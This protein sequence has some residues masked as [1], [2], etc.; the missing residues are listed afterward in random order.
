MVPVIRALQDAP[1]IELRCCVSTQ[2]REMLH[3][4]LDLFDIKPDYDLDVMRA[5]QDLTY[6]TVSVLEG[7]KPILADWQPDLV[8][9]HGDTT[10]AYAAALAAFYQRIPVGHVE[11]GL[12]TGDLDSPWPEEMNRLSVDMLSKLHFAP[13]QAAADNLKQEGIAENGIFVTGNTVVDSLLLT[14][15]RLKS[16]PQLLEEMAGRF[17]FLS[18]NLKTILVTAHRRESFGPGFDGICIALKELSGRSDIQIVYPVHPNPNVREVVL[19]KLRGLENIHLIEPL[20][21]LPFV[22]LMTRSDIILTDSGGIQEEAPSLDKPVLVMRDVTERQEAVTAGTVRMVGTDAIRIVEQASALL[23][24]EA[25]YAAMS[26]A[27]NPF[28]DG[29]AAARILNSILARAGNEF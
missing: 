19:G 26:T 17:N 25:A 29:Q 1:G 22:Y 12:R 5:A 11:A 14:A 8:L 2:H 28:G 16:D 27:Q 18:P 10:T 4:V 20:E 15:E 3:Q 13:T 7:M 23:D 6:I 24:D 9:V 21:Y